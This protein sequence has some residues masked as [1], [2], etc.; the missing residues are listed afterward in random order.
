[1]IKSTIELS[2]GQTTLLALM[3]KKFENVDM[4][5]RDRYDLEALQDKL[6]IVS[7]GQSYRLSLV[8]DNK[9]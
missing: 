3:L 8:E 7:G 6:H 5:P 1:M 9:E 2:L 4:K